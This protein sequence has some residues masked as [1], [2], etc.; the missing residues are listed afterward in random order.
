MN[1]NAPYNRTDFADFLR[2]FLPDDFVPSET[3]ISGN[4][5]AYKLGYSSSL[6]LEIF[7]IVHKHSN[8]ARVALANQAFDLMLHKSYCNNALAVFI[9]KDNNEQY[10][11]SLLKIKAEKGANRTERSYSDAKRF[12]F[13]LGKETK[14]KT[15]EMMF[16]ANGKID[17]IKERDRDKK[18]ITPFED[19]EY[20]F[21]KEVLTDKFYTEIYDWYLWALSTDN[22]FEVSYPKTNKEKYP[23][24]LLRLITRLM[25]VWFIKQK[26]LV[27]NEIFKEN[28][29]A[30][31]LNNFNSQSKSSGN[32][33]NA[34]LQNLFF[35]TL[36]KPIS[37]REFASKGGNLK[38]EHFDIKTLFRDNRNES[39]F[40]IGY[41]KFIELFETIPFLNGG[42]FECLSQDGFSREESRMAFLPNCLF[43][44]EPHEVLLEKYE[45]NQKWKNKNRK[46]SGLINIF[47][48]YN[49]TVDESNDNDVEISV[50]PELLG[51]VFEK[52]LG[53]YDFGRDESK[54]KETGSFYT[55][56]WVV[57]YMVNEVLDSYLKDGDKDLSSI[58]ILD[59][60]CG[61]GAFPIGIL[62]KLLEK[63]EPSPEKRYEIKKELIKKCIYGVDIQSIA[64]QI[65]KLRFFLSLITEQTKN[66]DKEKNYGIDP[67]PN[68]ETKFICANTLISLEK[69]KDNDNKELFNF[70]DDNLIKMK[71]ILWDIREDKNFNAKTWQEK[72]SL[73]EQDKNMCEEIKDYLEKLCKPDNKKIKEYEDQIE[74]LQKEKERYIG[75]NWIKVDTSEQM[76]MFDKIERKTL[77]EKDSH[78][79]QRDKIDKEIR[80]YQEK[81]KNEK[82]KKLNDSLAKEIE[83]MTQWDPYN[84]NADSPWF[85]SEWMFGIKDGFDIVIG[86]PPYISTKGVSDED[87]KLFEKEYGFSDDTYT[88]F[89]FKGFQLLN[90][91][92]SLTYITSK[93]FWTTQTKRNLRDLLL[94]KTI[95]YIFDTANPFKAAMVDT[96]II[97]IKNTETK[98]NQVKF[99]DGNQD[100]FNPKQYIIEQNI[101]LNA[102]NLVIFKPTRENLKI[103]KLYNEKVKELYNK[104]WNKISTS[105]NIEK[106]KTEL[107]TY[108]RNLKSG[109]ITL[110][111]CLTEGGQGLATANNGK[112]IAVRKSTKW[113]KNIIETRPKKLE[114]AMKKYKIQ[115]H[116]MKKF[117]NVSEYLN[118]LKE[119]QIAELFDNLKE[120]YGR[121][122]FVKGYIYRL[123]DDDEI[124]DVDTLTDDEKQNGISKT[125]KYY[126]PYDKGDKDGNRWYLETPFAIAWSKENVHYL[127]TDTKARYQGYTYF[128]REGFCWTFILNENSEYQKARIKQASI[129][130]VNAMAL[131]PIEGINLNS[132]FFVCLLNSYLIFSIKRNFINSTSSFQINDARQLPIIIPSKDQLSEFKIL[133]NLAIEIKQKQFSGRI[134]IIEAETKL[135]RIQEKLDQLVAE[136]YGI[137]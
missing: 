23:E 44:A 38:N 37:E 92:G 105:K 135:A 16:L 102:Q 63:R 8:V 34:I 111:G 117:T 17:K 94:S 87:K 68:L 69:N 42:L 98:D 89:F 72:K 128:F 126:V 36:N 59:P 83:Q 134:F 2:K 10:R 70:T 124:A 51:N 122:I 74:L 61:S 119:S 22:G 46:I 18:Q 65:C 123:I 14:T 7:E 56:K 96:C 26:A 40:K 80:E 58:K 118:S 9:P 121:D 3:P 78:K 28:E 13:L 12:S 66:N 52:L 127:K 137:I 99:L 132:D 27:P 81:I 103:Y 71:E 106:N 6:D 55:P 20:R 91:R 86:N 108:R 21:S 136:L 32:Y 33:Y 93:T 113:A 43:F 79:E 120:K 30:K 114:E 76:S 107:E 90:N 115:I 19:L 41:N 84:Q 95:D 82:N 101:Y 116:E 131:F 31:I 109:D 85:D 4:I 100:L 50:D 49:F 130:D 53:V 73:R 64:V 47:E 67:L 104:W 62:N 133:F 110:L 129:N 77:F 15:A 112:Y 54:R 24:H 25:F 5:N 1:F 125:K 11:F 75:E 60:A 29:I 57:N 45:Y 48:K 35:A 97:Y 88:H 39:F